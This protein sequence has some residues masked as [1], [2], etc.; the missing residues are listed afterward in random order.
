MT[1]LSLRG[2]NFTKTEQKNNHL[3]QIS[4]LPI[5]RYNLEVIQIHGSNCCCSYSSY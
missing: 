2:H 3:Q 4:T 1:K 5:R